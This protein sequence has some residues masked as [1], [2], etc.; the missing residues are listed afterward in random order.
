MYNTESSIYIVNLSLKLLLFFWLT[1]KDLLKIMKKGCH[2]SNLQ[3]KAN[4]GWLNAD[5]SF[6]FVN[7]FNL[8][9]VQYGL[10][11]VLNDDIITPG[12]GF[13]NPLALQGWNLR[14]IPM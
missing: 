2:S 3:G 12:L 13:E 11:R 5:Y 7:Y 14:T 8:N 6:S 10:L 9:L 4:L 1:Q